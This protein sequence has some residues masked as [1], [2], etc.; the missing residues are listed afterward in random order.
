MAVCDTSEP[1][2]WLL[3]VGDWDRGDFGRGGLIWGLQ[4]PEQSKAGATIQA[5][6]VWW[7]LPR[8]GQTLASLCFLFVC[9]FFV[10]RSVWKNSP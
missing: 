8:V 3:G 9:L 7:D 4:S 5:R 2:L 1:G 6:S 10:P